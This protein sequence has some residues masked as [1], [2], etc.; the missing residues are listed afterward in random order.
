MNTKNTYWHFRNVAAL[1]DEE[2]A[3]SSVMLDISRIKG[4][5]MG[6]ILDPSISRMTIHF[7]KSGNTQLLHEDYV[8]TNGMIVLNIGS[9]K[10]KE[11]MKDLAEL[12]NSS[13]NKKSYITIGDDVN[14]EYA[15]PYITSVYT[16]INT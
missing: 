14:K 9:G 8:T 4:M 10:G 11:V 7:E 13:N 3:Q 12:S 15:S 5:T 6:E 2:S 16:I 1:E